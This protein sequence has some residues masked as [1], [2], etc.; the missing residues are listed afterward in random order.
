MLRAM[1]C[2]AIG[3]ALLWLSSASFAEASAIQLVVRSPAA[4]QVVQNR[5]HL[6]PIQG[7]ATADSRPIHAYDLMLALDASY[8][9]NVA[10][11]ADVDGDGVVGVNPQT[12]FEIRGQYPEDVLST[13]PGDSIFAAQIKAARLFLKLL[14]PQMT[15]VGVLTFAGDMDAEGYRMHPDQKDA[16]LW[17]SLTSD[18]SQ[19]FARLAEIEAHGP[20][21]FGATNFAAGIQLGVA[22]LAG[23][24]GAQSA[25]RTD[26]KRL[27]LFLTDGKPT[28]PVGSGGVS[29][30]GDSQAAVSVAQVARVAGITIHTYALGPIA[31]TKPLALTEIAR[32]TLGSFLPLQKPADIVAALQT[33]SFANV[34]DVVF[35]NLTTGDFSTDVD[36]KPD[37]SFS[38]FVPVREGENRVRVTALSADGT[39]ESVEIDLMFE[40]SAL[41]EGELAEELER[42]RR[43]NKE[44]QLIAERKRIEEFRRKEQQR[45]ELE[46]TIENK[47]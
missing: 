10:S 28:F 1:F 35:K 21:E 29:D 31:L 3:I 7:S 40:I 23:L 17:V 12:D 22:E 42:I 24:S 5:V 20:N 2:R 8:S 6:A 16:K 45:K 39:Q 33:V 38:G 41:S 27:M 14:D 18:F 15:R 43:R 34:E 25:P 44:I 19:V 36:L 47:P 37:G 13:D 46:I 4:T 30:P 9:T 11:G 26:A 32:I